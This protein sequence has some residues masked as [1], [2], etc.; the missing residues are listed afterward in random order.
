MKNYKDEQ[1]RFLLGALF[2]ELRRGDWKPIWTIKPQD[3]EVGDITYPSLKRVYMSYDHVPG[4][5]YEFAMEQLGSW[6]HWEAI[7]NS[8]TLRDMVQEWRD[9]LTIK[10][11]ARAIRNL[12][13][14]S[15]DKGNIGLAANKYIANSEYVEKKI[16]RVSKAEKERQA[17]IAAGIRD[18]LQDDMERIGMVVVK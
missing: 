16:G 2:Y 15:K 13:S 1:G 11:K 8:G 17:R 4:H 12:M 5:E 3:F 9:E 10:L 14:L 18:N 6:Q 7:C